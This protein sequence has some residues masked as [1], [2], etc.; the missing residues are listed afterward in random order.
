MRY[1]FT[2]GRSVG[3]LADISSI[4]GGF[5]LTY[6]VTLAV[7]GHASFPYGGRDFLQTE[8]FCLISWIIALGLFVQY[9][10]RRMSGVHQEFGVVL[11]VNFIGALLFTAHSFIFKIEEFSRLYMIGYFLSVCL[12][13]FVNR[14]VIRLI[15]YMIRRYG[16]D[17]R[18]RII[19]GNDELARRYIEE[20][21]TR[22][23]LGL[24]I[25]GYV[26]HQ[27]SPDIP[28]RLLGTI[29]EI[30]DILV[31]HPVDGV[32]ICLRITDSSADDVIRACEQQGISMELLLDGLS[33]RI[34]TGNIH[35]GATGSSLLLSAIPHAPGPLLLKRLTDMI[36]SVVG[37]ILS[38]PIFLIAA[39]AIKLSD[40][41]PVF[42]KQERIGTHNK[43][44][45]MYKFRS[46]SIDAEDRKSGLRHL[47]EMSG[48]VFKLT[49][50]PRVTPV[51][52]FL[53]RTS[54][55]ELPQ[56]FNVL[57]GNMSLVGPRPPLPAEVVQYDPSYRKRLSVKP[58][59]TC[60]WQISGRSNVDFDEWMRL[61]LTY[62]DNWTYLEDL[63][64]MFKTIPVVL[65]GVG[66]R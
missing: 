4:V 40:G 64:I 6:F 26:A 1:L 18:T 5:Y 37:L 48:P 24:Q 38:S 21:Q 25:I 20:A 55:D 11:K 63:K 13:M 15:L 60:L 16:W 8:I 45:K 36:A 46:M 51:G 29:G 19:V 12:L 56:L 44:F 17:S 52:K 43:S 42:F 30:A 22:K 53:R 14:L 35:H 57:I 50:D 54:I 62:I 58:G 3:M 59:L 49:A 41:G 2:N 34:A 31:R 33:S 32:V 7:D 65:K 9:P 66:A 61:D 28:S 27:G 47:N 39:V 10:N 23:R